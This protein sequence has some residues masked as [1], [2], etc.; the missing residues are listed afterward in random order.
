MKIEPAIRMIVPPSVKP[1]SFKD[2][3]VSARILTF[4][5]Q[6]PIA[7]GGPLRYFYECECG[8]CGCPSFESTPE[9]HLPIGIHDHLQKHVELYHVGEKRT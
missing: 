1:I 3:P 5:L 7:F 8:H 9:N 4:K 6:S 2:F